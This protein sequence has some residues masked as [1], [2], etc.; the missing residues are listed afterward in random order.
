VAQPEQLPEQFP[1]H[2]VD[3]LAVSGGPAH[4]VSQGVELLLGLECGWLGGDDPYAHPGCHRTSN[5]VDR[6][7]RRLDYHLY[8]GQHL[9]GSAE[10]AERGLRGWALIHN[11][12]P[13]CPWT[14]RETPG[15]RSPAERLNG[16]WYHSE[17][18]Q[19]L[20]ISAR[21]PGSIT[22]PPRERSTSTP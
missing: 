7:L 11:F 13:S 16:R 4:M 18:L 12:A 6:L 10:V 17:W 20:L 15:L 21:P 19:N 9:H 1:F 14:V 5:L 3:P 2:G 22:R 8:C